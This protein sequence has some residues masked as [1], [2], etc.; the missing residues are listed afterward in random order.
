MLRKFEILVGGDIRPLPFV[1]S[2]PNNVKP[3]SLIITLTEKLLY[4]KN[5]NLVAEEN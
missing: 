2:H 4:V 3:C 1:G 5:L